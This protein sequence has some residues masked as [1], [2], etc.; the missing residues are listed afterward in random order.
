M[1]TGHASIHQWAAEQLFHLEEIADLSNGK[2]LPLV[3]E[4]TCFTGAFQVPGFSTLDESLVRKAAGGAIAAW[5]PTGL[6]IATGHEALAEGFLQAL[7]QEQAD[8]G[9]AALAGKLNLLERAP[10]FTDLVD[11]F[12]LL[13]DAATRLPLPTGEDTNFLPLIQH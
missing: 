5:G 9:T 1:Y 8:L 10:V 13:G 12:G 6:G 3:L 7:A 2:R 4:M 11:T